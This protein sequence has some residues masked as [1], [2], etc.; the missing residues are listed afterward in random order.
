[1]KSRKCPFCG[2]GNQIRIN[3]NIMKKI[4][5]NDRYSV[6]VF[7]ILCDTDKRKKQI[8]VVGK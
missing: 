7:L 6:N 3:Q 5:L 4:R 1:M 2:K 8:K